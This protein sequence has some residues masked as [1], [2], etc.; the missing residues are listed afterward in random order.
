M[1]NWRQFVNSKMLSFVEIPKVVF[2]FVTVITV[3]MYNCVRSSENYTSAWCEA[4][5]FSLTNILYFYD[6]AEC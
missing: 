3:V 5:C 2:H 6:S 1:K 4:I